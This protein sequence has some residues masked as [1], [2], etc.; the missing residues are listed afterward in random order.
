VVL[1]GC[2]HAGVIN[3]IDHARSI[4]RPVR[5]HALIGGIHLFSASEETLGWTAGKLKSFGVD[6][7]IG[8]HC[9]GLETVYR[10]RRDLGLDRTHAVVGAVG[11]TFEL[12]A[13]INPRNI[14]K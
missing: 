10:F 12:K 7:F 8:A 6:N 4:V 1:T 5:V 9:T 13:G 2:G 3:I 14:A 11:A